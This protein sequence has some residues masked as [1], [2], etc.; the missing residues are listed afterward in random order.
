MSVAVVVLVMAA[1]LVAVSFSEPIAAR[2][3]LPASVFLAIFGLVIG[4]GALF[5]Q[6]GAFGSGA[7]HAAEMIADLPLG[8]DAFLFVFLPLLL[9]QSAMNTEFRQI[10]DDSSTIFILAIVAVVISTFVI[11][12]ALAP[13]AGVPLAAC[14]LL[15]AIVATTDPIAVIGIF[16]EAGAPARLVRL[17]EGESL[18]NDAAAITLFALF[19][20]LIVTGQALG[21]G[22]TALKAIVMPLGGAA[23]GVVGGRVA[24]SLIGALRDNALAPTSVSLGLPYLCFVVAEHGFHVSGVM[25]VVT[26]GI[27]F[28][29]LGPAK[30]PPEIWRHLKAVWEQLDWW[31]ASMIFVLAS[32]LA[33]RLLVDATLHDL[34]LLVVLVI[35]AFVARGAIVFGLMPALAAINLAPRISAPFRWVILW[36]GLRGATT[37]VLALAVTERDAVPQE[38]RSFVAVLATGY[39]LFTLLV[40]GTTLRSLVR[41]TGLDRLSPVDQALRGD[42]FAAARARVAELVAAAAAAYGL[43]APPVDPEA[44]P[45][46]KA[47]STVNPEQRVA[48]AL[49]TLARAEREMIMEQVRERSVSLALV[50]RLLGDVRRLSDRSRAAGVEGYCQAYR[51]SLDF[52]W[53]ERAAQKV[54]RATGW[55]GWLA[56]ALADRFEALLVTSVALRRLSPFVDETILPVLG[57]Q[58]TAVAAATL[59]ERRDAV[60]RALAALRL[61][62]PDYAEALERRLL[63]NAALQLEESEYERMYEDGLIGPELR[64]DLLIDVGHRRSAADARPALDLGLDPRTLI[65]RLP[66]LSGLS[67]EALDRLTRLVEPVFARPGERLITTGDVGREAF[68]LSSG[69]VEVTSPSGE[70][71]RLGRGDIFGEIA[72]LTDRPRTADVDAIAY[73]SLL[74]LRRRAFEAFLDENPDARASI[75]ATAAGRLRA[76][77]AE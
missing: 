39:V 34:L 44:A 49:V 70:I 69:A 3:R 62:Y 43:S 11:G 8:S 63:G 55:S 50:D 51:H 53:T 7:E 54:A 18:L 2:M 65:A 74:R 10:V 76:N 59:A 48:V 58:P 9:F 56:R 23:L 20:D 46:A 42:V 64:R 12:F 1:L 68:F 36:G 25:A 57:I 61:Q 24:A 52:S 29:A 75:E 38:I 60:G 47:V 32:I 19:L 71:V 13:V 67:S 37:L 5:L 4:A 15:G 33:P 40:Q 77:A 31:A 30:A 6:S 45:P 72:L 66:L 16:R 22:E 73:C 41:T 35:A 27:T 17:V 14:L 26:A 28:A 21:A